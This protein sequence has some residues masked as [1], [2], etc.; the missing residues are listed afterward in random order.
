MF[1]SCSNLNGHGHDYS[2]QVRVSGEIDSETGMVVNLKELDRLSDRVL[3]ELD[4]KR[5]DVEVPYFTE[6]QPTGENIAKYIWDRLKEG[7]GESLVHISVGET[8]NSYFEYFEEASYL[9]E[10]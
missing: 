3:E 6:N 2:V 10:Y 1:K 7:L 4:H 5:L 9:D 8:K